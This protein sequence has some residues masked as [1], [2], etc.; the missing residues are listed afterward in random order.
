MES[1]K[2]Y[3]ET[4]LGKEVLVTSRE[5]DCVEQLLTAKRIKHTCCGAYGGDTKAGKLIASIKRSGCLADLIQGYDVDWCMHASSPEAA[6]V[7]IG[8]GIR[9]ICLTDTPHAVTVNKLCFPF[10]DWVV[11]PSCIDTHTLAT[12]GATKVQSY[13]GV[14]QVAWLKD[15]KPDESVVSRYVEGD[16]PLV[17]FRPPENQ[18]TYYASG[19][20]RPS[21]NLITELAQKYPKTKFIVMPRYVRQ[22]HDYESIIPD[23]VN[24]AILVNCIDAPSLMAKADLVMTGGGT[25]ALESALL[26]TPSI[27]YFPMDLDV[28]N[29]IQQRGFPIHQCKDVPSAL[30][31]ASRIIEERAKYDVKKQLNAL[32]SPINAIDKIIRRQ[33]R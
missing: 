7:A 32:E 19:D 21:V 9:N 23:N 12:M 3:V 22:H 1:I 16:N 30:R 13:K 27:T 6:R 24:M 15:F 17:I 5:H 14:D 18:A 31:T 29:Y 4:V 10:A 25:M 2:Q 33:E 8:L 28:V 20:E 26:G 11:A